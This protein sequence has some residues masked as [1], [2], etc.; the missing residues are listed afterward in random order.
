MATLG[1]GGIGKMRT[2]L[3]QELV[4]RGFRVDLLLG[5]QSGPYLK[6]LDS[7]ARLIN[8]GTTHSLTGLPRLISYLRDDH[9]VALITEKNR[10]NKLVLRAKWLSR[11]T[12][13]VYSSIHGPVSL[14][15][16]MLPPRK[17]R[18]MHRS[19]SRCYPLN[20]KIIA[21]SHGVGQDFIE[22][23]DY[24]REKLNVVGNPV[25]TRDIYENVKH[26]PGHPW[27]EDRTFP[28]VVSVGRLVEQK[29]YPTLISALN[30]LK[31]HK[32]CRL[33]ILGEGEKR[34]ELENMIR[35]LGLNDLIDLPGFVPNPYAFVDRADLFVL[36]SAWE[37]F[38]N[39]LVEALALGTPVVA[40]D[41]PFG[42]RE[43]VQNGR[44]GPLVPVGDPQ[45]MAQAME[46]VLR[47]PPD[48]KKLQGGTSAYTAEASADGY[49]K[50]IGL[51]G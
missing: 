1:T 41:C 5:H 44:L 22:T 30:L 2:H 10:V 15:L 34:S 20:R 27:L 6:K 46:K 23:F 12:V 14:K 18:Q 49:L 4:S 7:Q 47:H 48:K 36:S 9:P 31:S 43:I 51:M 50:T 25:I 37:G 21:V 28:V 40:T 35:T 26:P 39:V 19:M 11:S 3:I 42:P 8:M 38:G 45:A 33:I 24:P 16:A 29:D 17:R 32:P 13:P